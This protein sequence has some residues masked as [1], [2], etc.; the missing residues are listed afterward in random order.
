MAQASAIEN[1]A[2][3]TAPTQPSLNPTGTP[4]ASST[5]TR[6]PTGDDVGHLIRAGP[7]RQTIHTAHPSRSIQSSSTSADTRLPTRYT[8]SSSKGLNDGHSRSQHPSS[9]GATAAASS[10]MG[11]T[12]SGA[13]SFLSKLSSKFA[14]R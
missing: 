1:S 13:Q 4:L 9:A 14:R 7:D 8:D 10:M 12:G 6:G 11:G 5:N 2:V 3:T